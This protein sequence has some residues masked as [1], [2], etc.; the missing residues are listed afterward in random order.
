MLA[1]LAILLQ[2]KVA[3]AVLG[4]VIVGSTGATVAA[5]ATGHLPLIQSRATATATAETDHAKG[6]GDQSHD[7][8]SLVGT[9]KSYD[10][11]KN[12]ITVLGEHDAESN[13]EN[14]ATPEAT[15]DAKPEA[16]HT[17]VV[18]AAPTTFKVD[19]NTKV[20]GNHATTL[21]DLSKAIG[22]KVEIQAGK[23]ADG[24]LLARKVTVQGPGEQESGDQHN[25]EVQG[26]VVSVAA[27]SFVVKGEDGK[28]VTV[29]VSA[30]TKFAGALH[31]ISDLKMGER[32]DVKGNAQSDG[33]VVANVVSSE[34]ESATPGSGDQHGEAGVLGSVVSV[35][36]SSFVVKDLTG[37]QVTVTVGA[38]TQFSG[39]ARSLSDLKAGENVQVSGAA[40]ADGSVAATRVSVQAADGN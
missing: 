28:Q 1:K 15:Q 24:T 8:V 3:V 2:S 19:S 30:Q 33:S 21:A 39:G 9:L 10:A 18:D 6:N 23:Q 17:A 14:T 36:A 25:D 37:E 34:T 26:A 29:R 16:T 11:A 13:A 7:E 31:S 12:T 32:V 5:A 4:A 40:Q 35:G 20:N 22:H 38:S 27:D